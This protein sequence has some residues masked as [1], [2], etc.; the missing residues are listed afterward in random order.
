MITTVPARLLLSTRRSLF[1]FLNCSFNLKADSYQ[2][3]TVAVGT[4]VTSVS[5]SVLSSCPHEAHQPTVALCVSSL[6]SLWPTQTSPVHSQAAWTIL[7]PTTIIELTPHTSH[8]IIRNL[9]LIPHTS[10]SGTYTSYLTLTI[11]K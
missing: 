4:N 3:I 10:P 11:R 8:L 7:C 6:S 2:S 5:V 1:L 9:H